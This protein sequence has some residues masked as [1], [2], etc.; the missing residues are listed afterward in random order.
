MNLLAL[1]AY[2]QPARCPQWIFMLPFFLF[3][4]LII[5]GVIWLIRYLIRAGRERQRLR[6]ELAK[7]A[8]EVHLLRQHLDPNENKPSATDAP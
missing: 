6:L 8:E 2:V 7:L 4:P 3:Y 1:L 5:C